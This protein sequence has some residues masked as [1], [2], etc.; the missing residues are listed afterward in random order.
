MKRTRLKPRSD[1]QAARM[2]KVKPMYAARF[3]EHPLCEVPEC[4]KDST[5]PHHHT[6]L[7]RT[8]DGLFCFRVI[9][10]DHH[11]VFHHVRPKEAKL[12][13]Y[14]DCLTEDDWGKPNGGRA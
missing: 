12:N 1:K 13:G 10:G 14:L 9:C 4:W 8:G 2:R 5:Q 6:T 11:H 3:A 7:R